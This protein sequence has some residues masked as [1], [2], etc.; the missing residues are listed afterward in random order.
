M[1]R[2][3]LEEG[4]D[5]DQTFQGLKIGTVRWHFFVSDFFFEGAG[6]G[7]PKR[8]PTKREGYIFP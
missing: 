5:P 3:M 7:L 4:A 8:I 1:V 2:L 6:G